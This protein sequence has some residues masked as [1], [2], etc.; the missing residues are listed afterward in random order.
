MFNAFA[1]MLRREVRLLVRRPSRIAATIL[2]P[3]LLWAFFA[4]GFAGTVASAGDDAG[5]AYTLSL[6]AGAA[7]LVV[8]FASI[9]GAI[10]L[11]R[12]RETGHLQAVLVGPTPR[13][14][15]IAARV[16]GGAALACVQAVTMLLAAAALSEGVSVPGL[17]GAAGML[18][19]TAIGLS[20]TCTALAW[21]FRSIEGFHGVMSGLLMPAWLLSGA[22][23]LPGSTS[24]AMAAVMLFNPLAYAHA[25]MASLLGAGEP[26]PV[27]VVLAI[28]FGVA[29]FAAALVSARGD[30][31]R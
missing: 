31:K 27:A 4:G 1:A 14:I 18:V 17:A 9:F 30:A 10:G 8:T 7:L 24:D 29:G 11:I 26:Q 13:W 3:A 28:L 19:M 12:D 25:S 16:A 21:H 23:F 22:V 20:G 2:T 15:V 6:A 5:R